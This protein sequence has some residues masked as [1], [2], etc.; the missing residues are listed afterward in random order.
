MDVSQLTDRP[1]AGVD[2]LEWKTSRRLF[3]HYRP[4]ARGRSVLKLAGSYVTIDT[5]TQAQLDAATEAYLGGHLHVVTQVVADA[6][7]AAGYGAY[8]T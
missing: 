6:L 2:Y 7:T 1:D 8:V 4:L 5:P 3:G